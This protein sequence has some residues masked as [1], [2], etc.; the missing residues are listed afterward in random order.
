[1]ISEIVKEANLTGAKDK[2]VPY[3][4]G[5]LPLSKNDC[6]TDDQK[7][8]CTKYPYRRVVGQLMYGMVHTLITIMCALNIL[9][10]Y[11]NNPGPGYIAG[12][13]P[14]QDNTRVNELVCKKMKKYLLNYIELSYSEIRLTY[15]T[16]DSKTSALSN[17]FQIDRIDEFACV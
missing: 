10:R 11:G 14:S 6:A 13:Y 9:S 2:K 16:F 5:N 1:M 4:L 7:A 8:E 17:F 3:R 15:W 12:Q